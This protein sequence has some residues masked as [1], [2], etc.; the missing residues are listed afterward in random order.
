MEVKGD[1]MEGEGAWHASGDGLES[2][3]GE[4]FV[5]RGGERAVGEAAA[6]ID[7]G[8]G[9]D[10]W[11]GGDEARKFGEAFNGAVDDGSADGHT[12]GEIEMD[13]GWGVIGGGG[14]EGVVDAVEHLDEGFFAGGGEGGEEGEKHG[15]RWI[16]R[17]VDS[18]WGWQ[19]EESKEF[20][21][22]AMLFGR[23]E[24][25]ANVGVG[26]GA[27]EVDGDDGTMLFALEDEVERL[28]EDGGGSAA[29]DLGKFGVSFESA[30]EI[31]FLRDQIIGAVHLSEGTGNAEGKCGKVGSSAGKINFSG[32]I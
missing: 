16:P 1:G 10:R 17:K 29:G 3:E 26:V 5:T 15:I 28:A 21:A 22:M 18:S 24:V 14:E 23:E 30:V 11:G 20:G 2:S 19:R 6:S 31:D 32:E 8:H 9:G 4:L 13:G 27:E 7:G 12:V 25:E